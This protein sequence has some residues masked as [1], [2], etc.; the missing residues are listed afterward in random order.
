M[1]KNNNQ[2]NNKE[3][4]QAK[5]QKEKNPFAS[6]EEE[7]DR[8]YEGTPPM[9]DKYLDTCSHQTQTCSHEENNENGTPKTIT[10][11]SKRDSAQHGKTKHSKRNKKS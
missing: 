9:D 6:M 11:W 2:K 5:E 7:L 10:L 4:K 3:E 8:Y 1:K